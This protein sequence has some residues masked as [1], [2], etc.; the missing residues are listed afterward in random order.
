M[1]KK[2]ILSDGFLD[3]NMYDHVNNFRIQYKSEY[4]IILEFNRYMFKLI[5]K[6]LYKGSSQQNLFIIASIVEMH[7][8]YQ[9]S[10][11]LLERGL[12]ECAN[13]LIRTMLDLLIKIIEVVRNKGSVDTLLLNADYESLNIIDYLYNNKTFGMISEKHLIEM[14]NNKKAQINGKKNPR[15]KTKEL[16][17][18]NKVMDMYM[19]FRLESD[20]TH[21]STDVIGRIIKTN[22]KGY[23]IDENLIL[24]NFKMD[25][26]LSISI[27]CKMIEYIIN[28]YEEDLELKN[29]YKELSSK[30]EKQ[31]KN[32]LD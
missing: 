13:S 21:L 29:L 27:I 17:E 10:V 4:E 18:K 3:N 30:F 22:D 15:L 7:K 31:F 28:E 11:I 24:D 25:V 26:A 1:M 20:Y 16:A 9:S 14:I 19:L 2:Q 32:L 5:D 6:L 23:Y 12:P 8:F